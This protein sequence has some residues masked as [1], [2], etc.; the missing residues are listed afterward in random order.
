MFVAL[1]Q[2]KTSMETLKWK[3]DPIWTTISREIDVDLASMCWKKHI[4][5][6]NINTGNLRAPCG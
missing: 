1:K 2:L 3:F 4:V 5:Y 6:N